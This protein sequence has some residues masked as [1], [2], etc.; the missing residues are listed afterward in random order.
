MNYDVCKNII[1]SIIIQFLNI[2]WYMWVFC[3]CIILGLS[4]SN[5]N[6][7]LNNFFKEKTFLFLFFWKIRIRVLLIS[8]FFPI[9]E[10]RGIKRP[11]IFG[12]LQYLCIVFYQCLRP[13]K[14]AEKVCE[15]LQRLHW[16]GHKE[17][18]FNRSF[19]WFL[20]I[21]IDCYL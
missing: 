4:P 7:M 14:F 18:N 6:R 1:F 19:G 15:S 17:A 13:L 20:Y 11:R 21:Y 10:N 16:L 8:R 9:R 5:A 12:D 2:G 3:G